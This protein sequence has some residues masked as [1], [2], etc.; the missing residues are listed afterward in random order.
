MKDSLKIMLRT[1]HIPLYQ[2]Y[3]E[4]WSRFLYKATRGS[5]KATDI[6]SYSS[7]AY[8][9][10]LTGNPESP[11]TMDLTDYQELFCSSFPSSPPF[12]SSQE[13]IAFGAENGWFEHS[14]VANQHLFHRHEFYSGVWDRKLE[15]N[16]IELVNDSVL[17]CLDNWTPDK[18]ME[19][20]DVLVFDYNS[21]SIVSGM[22][23]LSLT[24][25][26]K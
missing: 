20:S 10:D 13:V 7:M 24:W 4:K 25:P 22:L 16:W 19:C 17:F 5:G 11:L 6:L 15:L 18:A 9:I 3:T 2:G 21:Q 26:E 8:M 14:F 23:Y 12:Q 1:E